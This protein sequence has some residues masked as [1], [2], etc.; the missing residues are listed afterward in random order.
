ML[1]YNIIIRYYYNISYLQL[2]DIVN[3]ISRCL[4]DVVLQLRYIDFDTSY[5]VHF[6]TD[7]FVPQKIIDPT[8]LYRLLSSSSFC[9][10]R[11]FLSWSISRRGVCA[12]ITC[13]K[14]V[15]RVL[16]VKANL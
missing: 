15:L 11:S 3:K 16:R 6:V 13:R 2:L 9:E 1:L 8:S 14:L 7:H 12:Q 10:Q 5:H 4:A